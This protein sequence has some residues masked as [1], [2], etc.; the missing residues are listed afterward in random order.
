MDRNSVPSRIWLFS[1]LCLFSLTASA[2]RIDVPVDLRG[3][4]LF[5]DSGATGGCCVAANLEEK[6]GTLLAVPLTPLPP[7][8]Y[9]LKARL[10]ISHTG[11]QATARLS[12][13]LR[14]GTATRGLADRGLTIVDFERARQYQDFAVP[15]VVTRSVRDAVLSVSWQWEQT[16]Q[17]R[18]ARRQLGDMEIPSVAAPDLDAGAAVETVSIDRPLSD[19]VYYLACDRVWLERVGEAVVGDLQVHKSRY[20]PGETAR[21]SGRVVN[22]ADGPRTWTVH[23]ERFDELDSAGVLATTN[24]SVA[25][26]ETGEFSLD[27][28]V[29]ERLWGHE[30]RCTLR[31]ATQGVAAVASVPFA[32]HTN[33][34]AVLLGSRTMDHTDYRARSLLDA[35]SPGTDIYRHATGIE[36]VFWAP[37]DFG[38][39]TPTNHYWSGQMRRENGPESTRALVRHFQS[40]GIGCAVYT[41]ICT[42]GGKA[43]YELM[44]QHPEWLTP[45]FFDVAQLD[46][47]ERSQRL[48]CWPMLSVNAGE[49]GAYRHH[50]RE[51]IASQRQF[52]WDAVRYDSSMSEPDMPR[53]FGMVK[54]TVNAACPGFQWGYNAGPPE[55]YAPGMFDLMCGGGGLIMEER[56]VHAIKDGWTTEKVAD[57]H[58]AWRGWVHS[59]GG[60]LAFCPYECEFLND[61]IYQEIL[62][63]CAR[64]HQ[65]WDATKGRDLGADYRRFSLRYAG[66][67]WDPAAT[68][69]TN[70]AAFVDWGAAAT[71]LFFPD[72]YA[73]IRPTGPDRSE[74][75]LHM[76]NR[77]PPVVGMSD[78]CWVP[79]PVEDA[80]C[81]LRLPPGLKAGTVH[82]LSPEQNPEQ[83]ELAA[84]LEGAVLVFSV[85][86][87]RFWNM[88]V[89]PLSGNGRWL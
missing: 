73:Y 87:L 18:S 10:K 25:A 75:I 13:G 57:R 28:P 62:P 82:C 4:S 78:A 76:V 12:F 71:N 79:P 33:M 27:V 31:D 65:A 80:T 14:V 16:R 11:V 66:Q 60:H 17:P 29:G 44:R 19:L 86:K 70:A 54:A 49:D 7:G 83:Q 34:W 51:I 64:A 89:I 36:F 81:R 74:L 8:V 39:L 55:V 35:P 32:V 20:V 68:A 88:L 9:C 38:N 67:V 56:N 15:L 42:A 59:R 40:R 22:A 69:L 84:S 6:S 23:A 61:A 30:I 5:V 58:L 52:G 3:T 21:V 41:K 50:A 53:L 26:G 47:W 77:P 48:A 2:Q 1:S 45:S 63:L 24:L 46:R 85:P 37:D 72:R 43:G